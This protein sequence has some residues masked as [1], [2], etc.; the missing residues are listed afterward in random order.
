MKSKFRKERYITQIY[1]DGVWKFRV[2]YGQHSKSFNEKDYL[3]SM[4]AFEAAISFRNKIMANKEEIASS[5]TIDE[6]WSMVND[7]YVLRSETQRKLNSQ[8]TKYVSLKDR[9][10][11]DITRADI[12]SDLNHMVDKASDDTIQRVLSIYKKIYGTAIAKELI[13]K[14]ITLSIKAPNSHKLRQQKRNEQIDEQSII[15]LSNALKKRLRFDIE[16][17]QAP[18][19][20]WMLYYTGMRPGELFALNVDDVDIKKKKIHINK[21]LG[22]DRNDNVIIRP[23]KTLKSHRIIPISDKLL[24]ILKEYLKNP[25]SNILF[26]NKDGKNY[27]VSQLGDR[28]HQIAKSIGIDFH[29]YQCRH[30]FITNLVLA[31][32]DI[33]TI[34][35]LVGQTID[36]TTISY[37]ISSEDRQKHA[38]NML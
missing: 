32:V 1:S 7:I 3:S 14:D 8:Y 19:I 4:K 15:E 21:E 30:S 22:S 34:Q 33:K 17:K 11:K 28:Y 29:F 9:P 16:K 25:T 36:Q 35:E 24:Q 27:Q 2:R 31:G 26:P 18:Y 10:L 12:I 38:I 13:D 6:V 20:L 5:I 23:C 37:I